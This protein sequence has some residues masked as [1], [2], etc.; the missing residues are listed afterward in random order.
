M[1]K[2]FQKIKG[3]AKEVAAEIIGDQNLQEEGRRD[4][5]DAADRKEDEPSPPVKKLHN[6][7]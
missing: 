3:A 5:L 2:T 1:A 4:R 6:L 7:P